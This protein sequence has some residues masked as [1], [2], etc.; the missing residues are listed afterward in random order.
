MLTLDR[1][2]GKRE[3]ERTGLQLHI[4]AKASLC[5]NKDALRSPKHL[6]PE[7]SPH[8]GDMRVYGEAACGGLGRSRKEAL[9]EDTASTACT[10]LHMC[11]FQLDGEQAKF[12]NRLSLEL[13][14]SSPPP[15]C[16]APTA[17][18]HGESKCAQGTALCP[19]QSAFPLG[20]AC[21][22]HT[23]SRCC[24]CCLN[25]I[26]MPQDLILLTGKQ[27][28]L[29]PFPLQAGSETSTKSIPAPSW[30]CLWLRTLVHA[31]TRSLLA[32]FP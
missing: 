28:Q 2:R 16:P 5:H 18:R 11:Y 12:S 30:T 17:C 9:G 8:R 23:P 7:T 22:L 15:R 32:C 4:H 31:P 13:K 29:F 20:D 25:L 14:S 19:G 21:T 26:A 24:C 1:P 27:L 10:S 6:L 3:G